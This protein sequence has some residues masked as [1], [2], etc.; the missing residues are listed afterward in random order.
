MGCW[1]HKRY[2]LLA[3]I[4]L[5]AVPR[6]GRTQENWVEAR[7]RNFVVVSDAG[8]DTAR[9]V[10]AEFEQFRSVF[11]AALPRMRLDPGKPM[12]ILAI[13]KRDTLERLLPGFFETE[14]RVRPSGVFAAGQEK[15][16]A[17]VQLAPGGEI[18]R[19]NLYHEYVHLLNRLNLRGI[20]V[21]LNEGLAEF[22]AT[23]RI[24]NHSATLGVPDEIHLAL[25]RAGRWL[26]LDRMLAVNHAS[27]EYNEQDRASLFYAQSWLLTHWLL[28]GQE[29]CD[30]GAKP[31]TAA[32]AGARP[33]GQR[34]DELLAALERGADPVQAASQV[35]G[36][37]AE[38][39]R[40]LHAYARQSSFHTIR[41]PA[42]E[43]TDIPNSIRTLSPAE[44][45]A[46]QGDFLLHT[47]R[48]VEAR[49]RFEEALR[50]DARFVAALEGLGQLALMEGKRAEA[51]TWFR[52]ALDAG[53][54]SYRA[55]YYYAMLAAETTDT[56]GVLEEV[57]GHLEKAV[58]LNPDFAPA[59]AALAGFYVSRPAL[60]GR[61]LELAR[62]AEELDPDTAEYSLLVG[63]VLLRMQRVDEAI[64]AGEGALARALGEQDRR[65]AQAFLASA[66]QYKE[67]LAEWER[68]R[69]AARAAGQTRQ[70]VER[71]GQPASETASDSAPP[72]PKWGAGP[73]RQ[74]FG[75][76]VEGWISSVTCRGK[77]MDLK[78][79]V[80]AYRLALH[81]GNYFAV[82][83]QTAG[84]SP[85]DN[86][87]PC[88]HLRG[89]RAVVLYTAL[90]GK[91]YAG[92]ILSIEIRQ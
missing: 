87:N 76:A 72:R 24:G 68:A 88:V 55:H 83:L 10:A 2:L 16:Y 69:K 66:R 28:L 25:L 54:H 53:A 92:E 73:R 1:A 13:E 85:P 8:P 14:G 62:K 42:A 50:L 23:T 7:S 70:R 61:A 36:D 90:E 77:T 21:W 20:P 81:S 71:E 5:L 65:E 59:C 80:A 19:H 39:E 78:I 3:L 58:A 31:A 60:L 91:P 11:R 79:E 56:P 86:F 74:V 40:R 33:C 12:V 26:P 49:S 44:V 84:W 63:R 38:A 41:V 37:S 57:E 75:A 29:G 89:R 17:A 27:P 34:M 22:Y 6:S 4:T 43:D 15:N 18:Q 48:L 51:R 64:R 35:L 67:D 47:H 32:G 45:L 46:L 52:R 9:R 82:G 30:V